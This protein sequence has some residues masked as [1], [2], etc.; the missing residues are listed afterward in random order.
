MPEARR[1]ADLCTPAALVDVAQLDANLRRG[2]DY[3]RAHGL[4]WRPHIKTHKTLELAERQLRAGATGVTVATQREA[5]LMAQLT[6]DVFVAFP[7]VDPHRLARL[8]ALPPHVRLRVAVDSLE[9]LER[10]GEAARRAGRT[11]GLM[12]ELDLGM[13]RVG[14]QQPA[15][16]VALA[17]AASQTQG[18]TYAGVCFYPGHIRVPLAEQHAPLEAVSAGLARFLEALEAAGLPPPEVSGGST[19]TLWRSHEVPGLTELRPGIHLFYDR[20]SA[21]L[22]ACRWEEISYSVLATVV[23]TAVPGQAVV[24]AGS[25]ALA[26]EEP[27][28]GEG[29]AAVAQRPEVLLRSLSEEHGLLDLRSTDWRPRVGER[30]RLVPNHVCVSV[31]LQEQLWG[32]RGDEVL[33]RWSVAA[34]GW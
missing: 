31:N 32:V 5:E 11:V 30:V 16:A 14:V 18:L 8:M 12:V 3:A 10:L 22:G 19:P 24:D 20:A 29:Y 23:S 34:R 21:L 33:H 15:E 2:A 28:R 7:P 25:K 4:R 27:P 9:V 26:K 6:D 1:L 13:R 17:R